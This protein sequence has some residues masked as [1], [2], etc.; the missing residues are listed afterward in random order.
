MNVLPSLASDILAN[1]P[2]D[3]KLYGKV[4]VLM[5]G[6]AEYDV[7]LNT[8]QGVL[9]ALQA[10][11][12]DAH[13]VLVRP[14]NGW[15]ADLLAAKYDR[16]FIALH[17]KV[18]EDG[19]VQAAL[20]IAEIPYTGCKVCSSVLAMHKLRTK[21]IWQAL[22]LP[23]LPYE[24]ITAGFNAHALVEKFGLP[25]AV[26]ASAAGSSYGVTKVKTIDQLDAAYALAREYDDTV[27]A[28][29]WIENKEYVVPIL[30]KY[31]LPSIH[32]APKQ[33]FFDYKAKYIDDDTEFFCPSGLSDAEEKELRNL[34]EQAYLSLGCTVMGRV[35]VLRDKAGKFWLVEVN[36][37][38]GLTDHSTT[39][40]AVKAL[41]YTYTDFV[42]AVLAM[43]LQTNL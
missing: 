32:I 9:N 42:L 4:G 25:L 7:S 22:G 40:R 10:I 39:P 37:I 2:R 33:E 16:V 1:A 35:D 41:G 13:K 43:T 3:P 38:P 6:Y 12:I 30:D 34:A 28:E 18:G 19:T 11:G 29:P 8:G 17:G 26:K 24:D 23:T 14:D 21:Q 15:Y 20:E 36:T 27:I 5:G 31:A